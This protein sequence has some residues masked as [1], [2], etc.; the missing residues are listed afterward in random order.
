MILHKNVRKMDKEQ[1]DKRVVEY[2]H[3]SVFYY[4]AKR[5]RFE[6]LDDDG[7]IE[8]RNILPSDLVVHSNQ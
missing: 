3:I 6:G 1:H 2:R 7:T 8:D 5:I 4:I